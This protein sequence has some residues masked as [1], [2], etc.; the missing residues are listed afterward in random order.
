MATWRCLLAWRTSYSGGRCY[1]SYRRASS[2]RSLELA[3]GCLGCDEGVHMIGEDLMEHIAY[4]DYWSL[5]RFVEGALS[6]PCVASLLVDN[7]T[8]QLGM[9]TLGV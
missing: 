7:I 2:P 6:T 8:L 1:A 9:Y 3:R 5:W 4:E